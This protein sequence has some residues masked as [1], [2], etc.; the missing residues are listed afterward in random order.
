MRRQVRTQR[1]VPVGP[2]EDDAGFRAPSCQSLDPVDVHVRVMNRPD[3]T[4]YGPRQRLQLLRA[5]N[6]RVFGDAP[7]VLER[8]TVRDDVQ[9]L[10]WTQRSQVPLVRFGHRVDEIAGR[11][12]Q[13]L[14]IFMTG[15]GKGGVYT[16][17]HGYDSAET[18]HQLEIR[19]E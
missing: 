18:S 16:V 14:V 4:E 6:R 13:S 5:R 12:C 8:V 9:M 3:E 11:A 7:S 17:V 10:R 2:Y 15:F 1:I 19:T